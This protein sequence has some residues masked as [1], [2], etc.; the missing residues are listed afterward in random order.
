MMS[1]RT[2]ELH[3]HLLE[4]FIHGEQ[5]LNSY[6]QGKEAAEMRVRRARAELLLTEAE[7][8]KAAK[9]YDQA[10]ALCKK[11]I[12]LLPDEPDAYLEG[13]RV[14]VK[15]RK[16]T[17]ALRMFRDAEDVAQDLPTP[18]Q[19]IGL[20]RVAQVKDYVEQSSQ[21]G[22]PVDK[23][24]V[25]R[26]MR[27]AVDAFRTSMDKADKI[28]ALNPDDQ[29]AK[30]QE[31]LAHIATSMLSLGLNEVLPE[32]HP[33]LL[34]LVGLAQECLTSRITGKTELT[35]LQLIPLALKAFY[36]GDHDRAEK[37]LFE[38]ARDPEAFNKA[39]IKLN[40]IGTQLR[41]MGDHNR[42]LSIYDKLLRLNPPFKGVI[43]F[44]QAIACQSKVAQEKPDTFV[45]RARSGGGKPAPGH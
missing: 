24:R 3:Y 27:E 44:N 20:C 39:C 17:A 15:K 41:R 21:N 28:K 34:E 32:S 37:D 6:R 22:S 29:E 19:E 10:V 2:K 30:R 23:D 18:N 31:A 7:K 45:Q 26:Y 43:L 5:R 16:Y 13:G 12:E 25:E 9:Q 4:H 14:L 38:A 8:M 11:A 35:A 33:Q 36:E 1:L 40:Y 42:A